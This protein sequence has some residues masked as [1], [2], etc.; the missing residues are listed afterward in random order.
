MIDCSLKYD[1]PLCF[2]INGMLTKKRKMDYPND[3]FWEMVSATKCKVLLE[4]DA[5]DV[6]TLS[7]I[8]VNKAFKL[9]KLWKLEKNLIDKMKI[10]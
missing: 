10:K 1:I 7:P 4:A 8:E 2:N 6:K 9:I 3:Y 5:H